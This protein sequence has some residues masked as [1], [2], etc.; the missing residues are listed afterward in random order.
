[1]IEKHKTGAATLLIHIL[2]NAATNIF[3]TRTVRGLVP[4]L[5]KTQVAIRFAMSYLESAAAT[6]NPPRSSMITGDHI[7]GKMNFAASAAESLPSE[8]F[9]EGNTLSI[10]HRNGT[11]REV[12]NKGIT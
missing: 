3:V 6:V 11:I 12:T 8:P 4:A 1:M 10:T 9:V 7:A 2:A 5:L